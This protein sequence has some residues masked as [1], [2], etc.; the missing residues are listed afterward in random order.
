M[1]LSITRNKRSKRKCSTERKEV[2]NSNKRIRI[3][4]NACPLSRKDDRERKGLRALAMKKY[5]TRYLQVFSTFIIVTL[6]LI[7][8]VSCSGR[9]SETDL[10]PDAIYSL[11]ALNVKDGIGTQSQTNVPSPADGEATAINT[12]S[13]IDGEANL[14]E[15][16]TKGGALNL[17]ENFGLPYQKSGGLTLLDNGALTDC[18]VIEVVTS[19]AIASYRQKHEEDPSTILADAG[20]V[21][22]LIWSAL[23]LYQDNGNSDGIFTYT[24]NPDGVAQLIEASVEQFNEILQGPYSTFTKVELFCADANSSSNLLTKANNPL[25]VSGTVEE[26]TNFELE[27]NITK[28]DGKIPE[29][30]NI[31][32]STNEIVNGKGSLSGTNQPNV[33]NTHNVEIIDVTGVTTRNGKLTLL[34]SN[35]LANCP[36][37]QAEIELKIASFR[38]KHKTNPSTI[39]EDAGDSRTALRVSLLRHNNDTYTTNESAQIIEASIEQISRVLQNSYS[40]F[41]DIELFCG[42]SN[43]LLTEANGSLIIE[44]IIFRLEGKLTNPN[45]NII[46]NF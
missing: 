43:N 12:A 19:V 6:L 35:T 45:K 32:I 1:S 20:G 27:G 16:E 10:E 46:I 23:F 11:A 31:G 28:P 30:I 13:I 18:S 39:K 36:E 8:C 22:G 29:S 4:K 5:F 15:E 2:N 14:R 40:I 17:V 38:L 37:I 3:P 9:T 42:D 7:F 33:P 24:S 26:I 44:E 41:I 34:N 21:F 25:L